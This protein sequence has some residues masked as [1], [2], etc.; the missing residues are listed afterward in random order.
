LI[1]G[2]RKEIIDI[3]KISKITNPLFNPD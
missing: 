3:N 2:W 1:N